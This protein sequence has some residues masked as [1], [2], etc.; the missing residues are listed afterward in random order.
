MAT[1]ARRGLARGILAPLRPAPFPMRTTPALARA[2]SSIR[3]QMREAKRRSEKEMFRG[4]AS[5]PSPSAEMAEQSDMMRNK[6]LLPGMS[7]RPAG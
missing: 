7:S 4:D 5:S 6:F 2:G 3:D 1:A